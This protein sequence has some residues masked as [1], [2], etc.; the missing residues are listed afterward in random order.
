M[1]LLARCFSHC[2]DVLH[3][4]SLVGWL[5]RVLIFLFFFLVSANN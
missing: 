1:I 3:A 2:Q 4:I 5:E